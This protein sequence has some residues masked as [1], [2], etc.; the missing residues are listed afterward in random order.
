MSGL[1][2][3]YKPFCN[4]GDRVF[5]R[6]GSHVCILYVIAFFSYNCLY[7]CMLRGPR[8][9]LALPT[10]LPSLNKVITYLLTY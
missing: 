8:G 10:E 2:V 1:M 7:V 3:Y 4:T 5:T 6:R 9:R